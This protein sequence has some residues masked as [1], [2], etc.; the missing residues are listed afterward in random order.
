MKNYLPIFLIAISTY[1]FGQSSKKEYNACAIE[2]ALM[3][4]YTTAIEYFSKVIELDPND[5]LAYFDRGMMKEFM[6]DYK[7]ALAD[8]SRQIEIDDSN[9]DSYFMRGIMNDRLNHKKAA[10]KD[11]K[12]VI[13]MEDGNADA[14]FFLGKIYVK[15]K[16]YNEAMT[17]FDKAISHQPD[18]A[19]Y[20]LERGDLNKL[21][22]HPESACLDYQQFKVLAPNTEVKRNESYCQ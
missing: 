18:N 16:M 9:V 12:K 1:S 21:L 14:H 7:G 2:Y 22:K 4:E 17:E 3:N 19:D 20:F 13:E 15:R 10:I 11:Y 8:Y 6:G 5:S